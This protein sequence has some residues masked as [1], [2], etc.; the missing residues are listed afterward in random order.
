MLLRRISTDKAKE[1]SEIQNRG[2]NSDVTAKEKQIIIEQRYSY[3]YCL[4][5][6]CDYNCH[7]YD[8]LLLHLNLPDVLLYFK[9][10]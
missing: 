6:N 2:S 10:F 1:K 5:I 4:L 9:I 3:N 7:N 8:K